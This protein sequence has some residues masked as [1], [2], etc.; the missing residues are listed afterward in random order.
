MIEIDLNGERK[1]LPEGLAV[2]DL[3]CYVGVPS[4]VA[5]VEKNGDVVEKER[6]AEEPVRDG[7]R[8]ELIRIVGGG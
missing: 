1:S 3:F 5:V 2:G 8:I 4:G 6:L 7:D